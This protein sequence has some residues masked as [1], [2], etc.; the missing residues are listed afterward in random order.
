MPK[1]QLGMHN[2][3][4]SHR[5]ASVCKQTYDASCMTSL[6]TKRL[7]PGTTKGYVLDGMAVACLTS[8]SGFMYRSLQAA[9]LNNL[10]AQP[11]LVRGWGL[12]TSRSCFKRLA[13]QAEGNCRA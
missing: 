2:N 3:V 1:G 11:F 6:P 5:I 13:V 8:A 7:R 4:Q 9:M 10:S 12:R